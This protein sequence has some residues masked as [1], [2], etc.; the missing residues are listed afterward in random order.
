MRRAKKA[1]DFK[2]QRMARASFL[3]E[4][5]INVTM[6]LSIA[7]PVTLPDPSAICAEFKLFPVH[8]SRYRRDGKIK[9]RKKNEVKKETHFRAMI[10]RSLSISYH[11]VE[12]DEVDGIYREVTRVQKEG[13]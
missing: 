1:E 10:S 6:P 12:D 3:P 4:R 13:G 8:T 7:F 5:L 11:K 2:R 9:K